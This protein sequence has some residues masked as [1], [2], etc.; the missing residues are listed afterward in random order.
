MDPNA[1]LYVSA[2]LSDLSYSECIHEGSMLELDLPLDSDDKVLGA[3]CLCANEAFK[4]ILML[5][6]AASHPLEVVIAFRGTSSWQTVLVNAQPARHATDPGG[7]ARVHKGY[8]DYYHEGVRDRLITALRGIVIEEAS[9]LPVAAIEWGAKLPEP[10]VIVTLTGHSLGGACAVV[11]ALDLVSSTWAECVSAH[12][13]LHEVHLVTFGMPPMGNAEFCECVNS[14]V[15]SSYRVVNPGDPAPDISV[16]FKHHV[17]QL[18]RLPADDNMQHLTHDEP[19]L[20]CQTGV[21]YG[22]NYP[23]MIQRPCQLHSSRAYLH[24]ARTMLLMQKRKNF[25]TTNARATAPQ[26]R[27]RLLCLR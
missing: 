3:V 18:V 14:L 22:V 15:P 19:A 20:N 6:K 7:R 21:N 12:I 1:R 10:K 4:A 8:H 5:K 17:G 11:C 16:L 24:G 25:T 26:I 13:K 2:L 9:H 27:R 23:C